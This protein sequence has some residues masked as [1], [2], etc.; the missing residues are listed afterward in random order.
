[1]T[2]IEIISAV[3]PT[4]LTST[5]LDI[6]NVVLPK[7]VLLIGKVDTKKYLVVGD[8]ATQAKNL[9]RLDLAGIT[10]L[11]ELEPDCIV[12]WESPAGSITIS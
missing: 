7:N 1:L 12:P 11:S 10:K 6:Y 5:T 9:P 8:G 2:V 4:E 3:I